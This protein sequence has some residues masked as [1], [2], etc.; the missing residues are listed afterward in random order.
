MDRPLD[1]DSGDLGSVT[2]LL[3]DFGVV[4]SLA[5]FLSFPIYKM[6]TMILIS[7]VQHLRSLNEN[8][9]I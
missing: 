8:G 6:G 1:W 9:Y 3:G 7:L 4:T 5:L 2:G